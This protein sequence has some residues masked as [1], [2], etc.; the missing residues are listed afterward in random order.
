MQPLFQAGQDHLPSQRAHEW[1][2]LAVE[3]FSNP[4]QELGATKGD[5]CGTEHGIGAVDFLDQV[6]MIEAF[7]IIP[8]RFWAR[9]FDVPLEESRHPFRIGIPLNGLQFRLR[10]VPEKCPC[11]VVNRRKARGM[12]A[13]FMNGEITYLSQVVNFNAWHCCAALLFC[14]I[15]NPFL[16]IILTLSEKSIPRSP[17]CWMPSQRWRN[18][19]HP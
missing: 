13:L 3:R 16:H 6:E 7:C 17:L 9:I 19:R 10:V 4:L 12:L 14:F 5:Q 15:R 8:S 11:A 1:A 2:E 18:A